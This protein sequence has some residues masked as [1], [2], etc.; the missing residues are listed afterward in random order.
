[1]SGVAEKTHHH[2]IIIG[3]GFAGLGMGIRLHQHG[4]TDFVLLERAA[5]VGGTW[6]DNRYPGCACD[7]PSQLYSFSFEL[8]PPGAAASPD[9]RRSGTTCATASTATTSVAI[10]VLTTMYSTPRGIIPG[11]AGRCTPTTASWP[12]TS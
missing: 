1:V 11:A 8:N 9:S 5:E 6:R 4:M 12:V 3:T 2:V 10:S 7:V